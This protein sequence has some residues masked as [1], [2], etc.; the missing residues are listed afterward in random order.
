MQKTLHRRCDPFGIDGKRKGSKWI[1]LQLIQDLPSLQE[2]KNLL[3]VCKRFKQV[4]HIDSQELRQGKSVALRLKHAISSFNAKEITT[5]DQ[6]WNMKGNFQLELSLGDPNVPDHCVIHRRSSYDGQ[7]HKEGFMFKF[8]TPWLAPPS[9]FAHN[10]ARI[11]IAWNLDP[12]DGHKVRLRICLVC[13]FQGDGQRSRRR[14]TLLG[15][16]NLSPSQAAQ[17]ATL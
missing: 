10:F 7:A 6:I 3:L 15:T 16:F 1:Y 4:F 11:D 17:Y 12:H 8:V 2:P 14:S 9:I 5:I 13:C